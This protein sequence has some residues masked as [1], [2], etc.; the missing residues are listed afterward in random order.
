MLL[1]PVVFPGSALTVLELPVVLLLWRALSPV[2]VL[3]SPSVLLTSALLPVAA[4][5]SPTVLLSS[6]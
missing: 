5:L 3:K 1:L 4:L 6:A 2:A